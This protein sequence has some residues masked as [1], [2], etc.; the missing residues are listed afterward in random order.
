MKKRTILSILIT[1]ICV[2]ITNKLWLSF[3]P[4]PVS[5]DISGDGSYKITAVLNKKNDDKF[6][7]VKKEDKNIDLTN[8]AINLTIDVYRAKNPKRLKLMF[9]KKSFT[10]NSIV[11]SNLQ[12]NNGELKLD[13][14]SNFS[15][16]KADLKI[17]DDKIILT[18]KN[19]N[20]EL[21]CATPLNIKAK[22]NFEPLLLITLSILIFLISYKLSSYLADF[23][24]I[25]NQ[26]RI[27][28]VFLTIFMI[29]LFIPM[30]HINVNAKSKTENRYLAKWPSFITES[31]TINYEFGK[32]YNEWFNDR[33]ALRD[34]FIQTNNFINCLLNV[35]LYKSGDITF[36]KKFN[37]LIRRKSFWGLE[38]FYKENKEEIYKS[39]ADNLIRLNNDLKKQNIKLYLLAIPRQCE[40]F[41]YNYPDRL[42]IR[43]DSM[44]DILDHLK[45]NTDV[46]FVYPKQEM[47]EANKESPVYF[48]TDTHWSK[49]G[50]Y[51]GYKSIIEL[52]QK[53]YP[54]VPLLEEKTLTPYYKKEVQYWWNAEFTEGQALM[55]IN[56]PK[57]I[58][59]NILDTDYIYY[60]NPNKDKLMVGEF[61]KIRNIDSSD[62]EFYYPDGA[63]LRVM[64]IQNSFGRNL[65][66]F[67][68]YSFKHTLRLYDNYRSM[69]MAE[70][71]PIIKD[72]KPDIIIIGFQ[73]SYTPKL[74]NIYENE[75]KDNK[76]QK[77]EN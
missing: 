64:L 25:K 8:E 62:E 18:P 54:S 46:K 29:F 1:I 51:I 23:K 17:K 16:L 22:V 45:K 59:K 70:Y 31:S 57:F 36:Y 41:D 26:S 19:N 75:D 21:I 53:D 69:N 20:F 60:K 2:I 49:K 5:F 6:I 71:E 7:K 10:K 14:L 66:E 13:D 47:L 61:T 33:F 72:F 28:I 37:L 76:L 48:K 42:S 27:E 30:S 55:Q 68:P 63:N 58:K 32:N 77:I 74:L 11:I 35:N 65:V 52:I 40:F 24:N 43:P 12:L 44:E 4:M 38:N 56:I 9:A 3:S 34:I 50:A 67:L 15:A 73:S 39:Y